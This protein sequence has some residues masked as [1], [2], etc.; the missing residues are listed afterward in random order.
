MTV[1]TQNQD[2]TESLAQPQAPA[3][4]QYRVL[5]TGSREWTDMNVI[6]Q[7]LDAALALLQAPVTMQ[8]TVSLVHGAAKGLDALAAQVAG[9]RG[10]KVEGYPA[11][12]NEHTAECPAWHLTPEPKPTCKMAGHRRN[13]EM[14]ALGADLVVA[15]PMG[16]ESSGY[17]KGTWGC[18]RAAM[19]AELPTVVVWK[20]SFH[21][22]GPKAEQL[23][24]A[25]RTASLKDPAQHTA[26]PAKLT[27][28]LPI[29]F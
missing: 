25:E 5:V 17:S 10:W 8:D 9:S 13:H 28:L 11:R 4:K 23:V 1:E 21:P 29:P 6:D 7:A 18:A 20:E 3:P 12:W 19:K 27:T 22:W 24:I 16:E 26:A 14:I 2:S 15:F